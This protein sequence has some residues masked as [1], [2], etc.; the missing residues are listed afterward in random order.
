MKTK[1]VRTRLLTEKQ[2]KEFDQIK[3]YLK[4]EGEDCSDSA[5]LRYAV[6]VARK[7]MGVEGAEA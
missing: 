7:W 4:S 1:P 5:V 3:K 6:R 2:I